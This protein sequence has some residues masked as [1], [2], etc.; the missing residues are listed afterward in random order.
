MLEDQRD[1]Y[2]NYGSWHFVVKGTRKTAQEIDV[3]L[4]DNGDEAV[5]YISG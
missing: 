5:E 2:P 1:H 3:I 4:I